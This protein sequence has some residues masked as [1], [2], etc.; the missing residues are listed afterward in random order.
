MI[1]YNQYNDLNYQ[2][3]QGK[4]LKYKYNMLSLI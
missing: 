1:N 4:T 3:A 2:T